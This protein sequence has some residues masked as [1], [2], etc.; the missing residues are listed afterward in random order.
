M[1]SAK[2]VF[3][4]LLSP[5]TQKKMNVKAGPI[6]LMCNDGSNISMIC[7]DNSLKT[8]YGGAEGK[9]GTLTPPQISGKID[10]KKMQISGKAG[11]MFS[12]FTGKAGLKF[13][14]PFTAIKVK[15]GVKGHLGGLGASASASI[16]KKGLKVKADGALGIGAGGYFDV[17]W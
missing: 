7:T 17:D 1:S 12:T 6:K 9:I 2:E 3:D 5:D 8:K 15:C 11:A 14:V 16:G 10:E 4:K 13:N